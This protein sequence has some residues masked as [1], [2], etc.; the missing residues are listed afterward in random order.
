MTTASTALQ[1]ASSMYELRRF[2]GVAQLHALR[3]GVHSEEGTL[4]VEKLAA[5]ETLV[6]T[7]PKTYEQDG[8]DVHITERDMCEGPQ[9]QAFGL[10]DLGHGGELGYI[11]IADIIKHGVELDLHFTPATL[12]SIK[13]RH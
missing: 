13:K 2:I 1:A 12:A 6:K 7:M 3:A 8:M 11:S 4:F 9:L 10:A 5:L